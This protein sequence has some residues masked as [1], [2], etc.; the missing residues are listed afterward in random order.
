MKKSKS[1]AL[2]LILTLLATCVVGTT[3][4]WLQ[5]ETQTVTNT[6]APA[7]IEITLAESGTSKDGD[8]DVKDYKMIPGTTESKDPKVTVLADSEECYLFVEVIRENNFD[9]FITSAIADGWTNLN[10]QD[11]EVYYRT[12]AADDEDQAFDI[13]AGNTVTVKGTITNDDMATIVEG[14]EPTISFKAYAIQTANIDSVEA[15]WAEA[16]K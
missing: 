13:L 3:I 11:R 16:S 2:V 14:E 6:F 12:V 5:D 7:G 8:N 10:L 15:A 9:H 4:A 1:I